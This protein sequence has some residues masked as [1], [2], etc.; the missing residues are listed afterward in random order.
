[1][2]AGPLRA[3]AR[4]PDRRATRS[5]AP[6]VVAA[7]TPVVYVI[8]KGDTLSKVANKF[9]V[10]IEDLLAANPD[11]KD[12]NKISLGQEIIIPTPSAAPPAA[13]EEP[14]ASTVP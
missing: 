3:R 13:S 10:E 7:P 6:S 11:I 5:A 12:P 2:A 9:D 4:A 1:M 14:E 8:K